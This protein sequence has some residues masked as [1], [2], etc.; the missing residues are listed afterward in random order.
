MTIENDE[1]DEVRAFI[2]RDRANNN[3]GKSAWFSIREDGEYEVR[4][5]KLAPFRSGDHWDVIKGDD[6]KKQTIAC[7]RIILGKPCPI[8]ELVDQL[9]ESESEED[10][11]KAK[12]LAAQERYPMVVLEVGNGDDQPKIYQAPKSVYY[13][14]WE[15]ISQASGGYKDLLS[16]Q[17]GRNIIIKRSKKPGKRWTDYTVVP[18]PDRTALDS[19]L[20]NQEL[21]DSLLNNLTPRSYEDI[22]YAMDHGKFPDLQEDKPK[23]RVVA[24]S[25]PVPT[26]YS[27]GLP[28]PKTRHEEPEEIEE[29][30]MEDIPEPQPRPVAPSVPRRMGIN[31]DLKQKVAMMQKRS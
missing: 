15:L 31:Q 17:R 7:P 27:K 2:E 8:C 16:F 5:L 3:K 14:V 4:V 21:I 11:A 19:E 6:G 30:E 20:V 9:M 28:A 12:D 22:E 13:G 24:K 1:L 18:S 25:K 10:H 29:E 26:S 23:A